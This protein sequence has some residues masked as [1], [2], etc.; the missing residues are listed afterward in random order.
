MKT[1]PPIVSA[2]IP[3]NKEDLFWVLIRLYQLMNDVDPFGNSLD[4]DE[5]D[6]FLFEV[7]KS[8]T[9]KK[10]EVIEPTTERP[11][12]FQ[13]LYAAQDDFNMGMID[14]YIG[15]FAI[16]SA[17]LNN[18]PT[19]KK[20]FIE[21]ARQQGQNIEYT[22]DEAQEKKPT[23]SIVPPQKDSPDNGEKPPKK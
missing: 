20:E 19:L 6:A 2:T 22:T 1:T 17:P 10:E 18:D 21:Y 16:L 23:L 9:E 12:H 3:I 7:E 15:L 14:E 4:E 11:N 13:T 5:G 8:K